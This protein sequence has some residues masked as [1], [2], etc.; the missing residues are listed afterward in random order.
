MRKKGLLRRVSHVF[1]PETCLFCGEPVHCGGLFCGKCAEKR[2]Q[3]LVPEDICANCGKTLTSC[4][5][6]L[7]TLSV[8]FYEEGAKRA[9]RRMKFGGERLCAQKLA[10]LMAKQYQTSGLSLPDLLIPVPLHWM[11]RYARGFSQTEW[12]CKSLSKELHVPWDG[13]LLKKC[14]RTKKQHSL[15]AEERQR[16]LKGVFSVQGGERISGRRILLVDDVATTGATLRET[17]HILK[18]AGAGEVICLT[19]AKTRFTEKAVL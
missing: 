13:H 8:Y 5:C 7:K 6:G 12:L 3:P 11:D 18:E 16:N 1:F 2:H 10:F 15:N 4:A 14:R 19:A 9:V 17:A